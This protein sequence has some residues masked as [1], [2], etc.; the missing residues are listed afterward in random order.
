MFCG[1]VMM[2]LTGATVAGAA[3]VVSVL[4]V[5]VESVASWSGCPPPQ[6]NRQNSATL[7]ESVGRIER[8]IVDVF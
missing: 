7:T 5:V 1:V 2:V 4:T 8:F 3:V 6:E